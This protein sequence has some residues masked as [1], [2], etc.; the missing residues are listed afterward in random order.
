MIS[1]SGL[2]IIL[3]EGLSRK[4]IFPLPPSRRRHRTWTCGISLVEKG[5]TQQKIDKVLDPEYSIGVRKAPGA[6]APVAVK[7][8]HP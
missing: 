4:V 7:G 3:S 5:L 2:P 6:P 8:C 1:R